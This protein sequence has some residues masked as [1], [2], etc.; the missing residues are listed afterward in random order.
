MKFRHLILLFV[1]LLFVYCSKDS[2]PQIEPIP[3]EQSKFLTIFHINDPHGQIDNFAKVKYI[4]DAE[5]DTTNVIVTCGGDIFS[6]NPVVDYHPEKG[7]PMI[8]LMNQIGFDICALGNHEFDYGPAILADRMEQANFD[9]VCA[10]VD[11]GTTSIPDPFEYSSITVEDLKVS[12][13]G[14][15]ETNGKEDAIIPSTHPWRVQDLIFEKPQDVVAQFSSIKEQEE[16]DLYV[17]LTHLGYSGSGFKDYDLAH[18]YPYFDLILGGHSHSTLA[19]SANNI[20]VFQAGGYL[21]K[22]V[23]IMLEIKERKIESYSYEMIDLNA[24]SNYDTQLQTIID[25]YNNLPYLYEVIGNS[26]SYHSK[27]EVGCFYTDALRLKMNVDITIQNTGGVRSD[28]D[29][30]DITRRDIFEISP[31]NN[32]TVIYEMTVADIKDL[33]IGSG[34]GFYYSGVHIEQQNTDIKISDLNGNEL[35]DQAI[36]RLGSNDYIPAVY[37]NYFP[38][39]GEVQS[40]TAAETIISYLEEINSEVDY[41]NCERYFRYEFQ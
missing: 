11:P 5:R 30:G 33:F 22:M 25:D 27:A 35:H 16:A 28:L 32:G 21:N 36:L 9:W 12:F 34:A 4:I 24:Y 20:P 13:L 19:T 7:Y 26:L 6:G 31:F 3:T 37:D 14:L 40:L 41:E 15:V 2:D 10:N 38:T 17:A 29:E 18:D 1:P 39:N 8:D 23:K